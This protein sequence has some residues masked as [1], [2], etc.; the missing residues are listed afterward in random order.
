MPSVPFYGWENCELVIR[1]LTVLQKNLSLFKNRLQNFFPEMS[2]SILLRSK[3][4][5]IMLIQLLIH[6]QD[7]LQQ[8]FQTC[9]HVAIFFF[10]KDAQSPSE[11]F[12]MWFWHYYFKIYLKILYIIY[13]RNMYFFKFLGSWMCS[14]DSKPWSR[15]QA[16]WLL[17]VGIN[18]R[19]VQP[20]TNSY[21]Y[22]WLS[23]KKYIIMFCSTYFP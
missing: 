4:F 23:I 5:L 16:S 6:S 9:L 17:Y 18:T 11:E 22:E 19:Y 14:H 20:N 12:G 3:A 8:V 13:K 15:I 10:L 1:N 7:D 2:D 21:K